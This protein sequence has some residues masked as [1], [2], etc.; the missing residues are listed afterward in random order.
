MRHKSAP[1]A[2]FNVVAKQN[3]LTNPP[4]YAVEHALKR[5]GANLRTARL[6]RNLTIAEAATKIGVGP[7]AVSAAEAGKPGTAVGAYLGLLWAYGLIGQTAELADPTRDE[8]VQRAARLRQH[9][10]PSHK[11][12]LDNDF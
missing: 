4:P 11:G 7:R 3:Q 1:F 8:F 6:A 12:A 10:Y 5:L 9:A 2:L